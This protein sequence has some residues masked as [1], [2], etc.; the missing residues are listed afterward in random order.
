MFKRERERAGEKNRGRSHGRGEEIREG[1][2]NG[3]GGKEGG[4]KEITTEGR[5]EVGRGEMDG[6]RERFWEYLP[7]LVTLNGCFRLQVPSA[8]HSGPKKTH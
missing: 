6:R 8:I 1:E 7:S 5:E 4:K 2:R 3:R